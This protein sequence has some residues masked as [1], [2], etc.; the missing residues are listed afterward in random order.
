MWLSSAHNMTANTHE[1]KGNKKGQVPRLQA[2][3]CGVLWPEKGTW[4]KLMLTTMEVLST[5]A[6][7]ETR[8]RHV[9]VQAN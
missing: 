7:H 5:L 9:G 6:L 4:K 1:Q 8:D 2:P 3:T